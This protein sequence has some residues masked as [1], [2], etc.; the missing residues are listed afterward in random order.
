MTQLTADVQLMIAQN[1]SRLPGPANRPRIREA[2]AADDF[3]QHD[4]MVEQ[5]S[6]TA[7][8][9]P[10]GVSILPRRLERRTENKPRQAYAL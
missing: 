2:A 7:S 8:D 10:F 5:L 9:P 6:P 1:L 4:D 3:L